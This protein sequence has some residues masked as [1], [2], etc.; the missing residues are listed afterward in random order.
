MR[1]LR[2]RSSPILIALLAIAMQATAMLAHMHVHGHAH[3]HAAVGAR[4]WAQGVV[5]LACRSF[6][7]QGCPAVP[8]QPERDCPMCYALA[9]AGTAVLPI[10]I[11][12]RSAPQ[13]Y[14]VLQPPRIAVPLTAPTTA[15]FQA[16]APPLA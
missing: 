2:R 16:R 8:Q 6:V 9:A 10:V 12:V 4:A 14:E 3:G 11:Q 1:F 7:R 13:P 15:H 5:S